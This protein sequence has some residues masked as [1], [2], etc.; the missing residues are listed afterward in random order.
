MCVA[1]AFGSRSFARD[2][3]VAVGVVLITY[4][5]F[6]RL[7]GLQLPPGVLAGLI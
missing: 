1:F 5:G 7:L 6:T 4:V 2:A 3:I